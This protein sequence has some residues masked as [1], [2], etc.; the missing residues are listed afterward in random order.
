MWSLITGTTLPAPLPHQPHYAILGLANNHRK[1]CLC[2]EYKAI[3]KLKILKLLHRLFQ[4]TQHHA[5]PK[6]LI[7]STGLPFSWCHGASDSAIYR[8][9]L[10]ACILSISVQSYFA[11]HPIISRMTTFTHERHAYV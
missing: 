1:V 4:R 10:T 5:W 6:A 7:S 9:S 11:V 3:F 8:I 2:T